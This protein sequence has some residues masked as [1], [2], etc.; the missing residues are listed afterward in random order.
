MEVYLTGGASVRLGPSEFVAQGGQASVYAVGERAYK[1]Y[2]DPSQSIPP[3][4][5][6]E[7]AALTRGS[8]IR[9]EEPL[10][11]GTGQ[12]VGYAM[13]R[14]RDAHALGQLFTGFHPYRGKHPTLQDMD[15]RMR[16]NVSVLNA[17][18]RVPAACTPISAI[19]PNY[20]EWYRAV[21]EHGER[22]SPPDGPRAP[23]TV[24]PA[25]STF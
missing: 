7:L 16:H 12:P 11:D 18:V 10:F 3:A 25:L 8:F 13:R 17:E 19:P 15:A 21:L 1:I 22:S 6:A 9:P 4:R 20:L 24:V 23:I 14:V 5:I 2:G